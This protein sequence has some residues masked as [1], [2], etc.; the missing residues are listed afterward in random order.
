MTLLGIGESVS[1]PIET[2]KLAAG[3]RAL[4]FT[5]GLYGARRTDGSRQQVDDVSAAFSVETNAVK[6][7]ER[8]QANGHTDDDL[9]VI[10]IRR[11]EES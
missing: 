6:L 4:L 11:D 2:V 10:M 8:M 3:D 5:D 7:A 9:T 1:G